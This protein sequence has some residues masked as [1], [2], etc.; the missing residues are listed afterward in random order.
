MCKKKFESVT[1]IWITG[2]SEESTIFMKFINCFYFHN[3]CGPICLKAPPPPQLWEMMLPDILLAVLFADML[4]NF[5]MNP[6]FRWF[7]F[8][9]VTVEAA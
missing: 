8:R 2:G 3:L 9:I 4:E 6:H 7:L 1:H 5:K